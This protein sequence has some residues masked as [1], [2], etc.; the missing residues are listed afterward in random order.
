MKYLILIIVL[1][2]V[3]LNFRNE[4]REDGYWVIFPLTFLYLVIII[5]WLILFFVCD[6]DLPEVT[7]TL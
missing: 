4:W 7:F 1:A 2:I 6:I 3:T 5:I